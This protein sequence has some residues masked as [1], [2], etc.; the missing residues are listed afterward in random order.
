MPRIL[1]DADIHFGVPN[2]LQDTLWALR[3]EREYARRHGIDTIITLAD[4]FHSRE[5]LDIDVMCAAWDFLKESKERY[6]QRRITFPGN[7]DMFLKHSWAINTLKPFSGLLTVID[8][9][10]IL[11]LNGVRFW[12]LPFI[13]FESA[14]MRVLA[15]IH[16]Q[17]QPGDVLLTHIGT[18]SAIKNVCFLLKDWS[19]V[20]FHASPFEQVYTGHFHITQQVGTNTWY[21]GSL[22][23]FKADEGDCQHGFFV[24]DLDT[25]THEFVD[26]WEKGA[27]YFPE[28]QPPPNYLTIPEE[29]VA[30]VTPSMARNNILRVAASREYTSTEQADVE[31]RFQALGCRAVRWMNVGGDADPVRTRAAISASGDMFDEWL[32]IDAAN[33]DDLDHGL[34]L[35]LHA[36]VAREADELYDY[37]EDD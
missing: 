31:A 30:E 19:A 1:I 10:K 35:G 14:Y 3:V 27:E 4:M 11:Q 32:K 2:R 9:V 5:S 12:V 16:K 29:M 17:W 36:E 23:P 24:Y 20:S 25:R 22:I 15:E 33:T 8:T 26:I 6:G 21:P 34:L 37:S 18:F 7:H 13:H 28:E